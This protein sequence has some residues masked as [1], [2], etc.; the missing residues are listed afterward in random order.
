MHD[1]PAHAEL[2]ARDLLLDGNQSLAYF[3]RCGVHRHRHLAGHRLEPYPG[4]GV[5]VKTLREAHVLVGHRVADPPHHAL[6]V[7][8]VGHAAG[9]VTQ[10]RLTVRRSR[11][12]QRHRLHPPQQL[13][14]RCR[15]VDHLPGRRLRPFSQRVA[16]AQLHRVHPEHGGQ[17]IHL[18][19]VRESACTEP[20]PRIA[21]HGGLLVYA[22]YASTCTFGTTYGPTP[23]VP[24][25]PTTAGVLDA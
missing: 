21:P 20:K 2:G 5:V 11:R 22:P 9:Q 18:G 4:G 25:L 13:L 24:T 14:D 23:I 6:T 7:G 8:G 17:L 3:G 16:G 12:R 10:G 15:A 19:L 1:D